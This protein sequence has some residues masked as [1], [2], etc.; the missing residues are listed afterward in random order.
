M[1]NK[2]QQNAEHAS[3]QEGYRKRLRGA[4]GNAQQSK[5]TVSEVEKGERQQK[6]EENGPGVRTTGN[7]PHPDQERCGA[8]KAADAVDEAQAKLLNHGFTCSRGE[9]VLKTDARP[10]GWS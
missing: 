8:G 9:R 6:K 1:E 7:V 10:N 5:G 4:Q 3:E 2:Q